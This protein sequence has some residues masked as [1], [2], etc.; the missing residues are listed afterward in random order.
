VLRRALM[1]RYTW[2]AQFP[3]FRGTWQLVEQ[4]KAPI[5][6][7]FSVGSDLSVR[8]EAAND[9][10]R[11]T[12]RN[13]ISSFIT[14]R[15]EVPFDTAY[16]DTTFARSATRPDGTVVVIAANDP[17]ATTYTVKGGEV[18]E[19]SRSVGRLS[20]TARDREKMSTEDGRTLSVDYDVV[21]TSNQDQSQLAVEHTRDTYAKVGRYWVPS[22]RRVE[23]TEA[24]QAPILRE[25]TLTAL[26]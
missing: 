24:G 20:Y 18:I 21:Y 11:A 10:A 15:K 8:V 4:G 26:R 16:A 22:G 12:M 19:V 7:A 13:E 3:G 23:R 1:K 9:T 2:D 25:I 14:Q 5:T 6:G 17:L